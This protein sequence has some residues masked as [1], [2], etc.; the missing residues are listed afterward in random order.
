MAIQSS[1]KT[2]AFTWSTIVDIWTKKSTR[3]ARAQSFYTKVGPTSWKKAFPFFPQN[4]IVLYDGTLPAD[5]VLCDGT[6]DT[7]DLVGAF[8]KCGSAA[9][10]KEGTES[11]T[12]GSASASTSSY[13]KDVERKSGAEAGIADDGS[14]SHNVESHTH[15]SASNLPKYLEAQFARI[16]QDHRGEISILLFYIDVLSK[17][18]PHGWNAIDTYNGRF[19]RGQN[20]SGINTGGSSSHAHYKSIDTDD[21]LEN[22]T[23][24]EGTRTAARKHFHSA[25]HDAEAENNPPHISTRLLRFTEEAVFTT[26]LTALFWGAPPEGWISLY[27][28]GLDG[29]LI[30]IENETSL[31][32]KGSATHNDISPNTNTGYASFTALGYDNGNDA[33]AD[34]RH[35]LYSHDHGAASSM[36]VNTPVI[37]AIRDVD[38]LGQLH[39]W[40]F[41]SNG[42]D[43]YGIMDMSLNG[44]VAFENVNGENVVTLDQEDTQYLRAKRENFEKV[45]WYDQVE[46]ILGRFE[47]SVT[48]GE[49]DACIAERKNR[50]RIEID[51]SVETEQTV[52]FYFDGTEI[53]STIAHYGNPYQFGIAIDKDQNIDCFF[54]G[55][56]IAS[57]AGSATFDPSDD[58]DLVLGRDASLSKPARGHFNDWMDFNV[59]L[60]PIDVAL[61][62][63]DYDQWVDAGMG[64]LTDYVEPQDDSS[65]YIDPS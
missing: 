44:S 10:S 39:R 17:G 42:A 19:V 53:A 8:P 11:H 22:I 24:I 15:D 33:P 61:I 60:R 34:H 40:T 51:Q 20:S 21:R 31:I 23:G 52:R 37:I 25:N 14:H 65:T 54:N 1:V 38:F 45:I 62:D 30:K 12:T 36:P 55:K 43:S 9:G 48:N 46:T 56:H 35:T 32:K 59:A 6:N 57:H 7:P 29:S 5:F 4:M 49:P 47:S 41:D 63:Q 3:W 13:G 50:W 28:L 18:V 58:I 26:G 16:D 27:E 64:E 2:D